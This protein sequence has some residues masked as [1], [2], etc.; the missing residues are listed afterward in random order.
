M[1]F[2]PKCGTMLEPVRKGKKTL[3][4]CP[5]CGY[6]EAL[7]RKSSKEYKIVMK[8]NAQEKVKTTSL[9]SEGRSVQRRKEEIEQEKEEFY[10][11]LLDLM[12]EETG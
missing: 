1:K 8:S 9:V 3:L 10:E 7:G 2:C 6:E 4:R 11:V 5:S 12:S